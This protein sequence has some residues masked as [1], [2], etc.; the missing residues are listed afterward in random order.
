MILKWLRLDYQ[1]AVETAPVVVHAVVV[2][3]SDLYF[4]KVV[5]EQVGSGL[6][7]DVV[8]S[9]YLFSFTYL[10]QVQRL[11]SSSYESILAIISMYYFLKIK[12]GNET[13]R[14]NVGKV[15]ALQTLSFIVRNTSPIG[16]VPILVLK[17]FECGFAEIICQY[18]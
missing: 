1:P 3:V 6:G 8:M 13:N 7:Y 4:M 14:S 12:K 11:F 15:V 9:M 18:L 16:W 17:A 5:E 10:L 2:W